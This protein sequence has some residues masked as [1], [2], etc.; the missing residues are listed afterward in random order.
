MWKFFPSL[1]FYGIKILK[2]LR[3]ALES[4]VCLTDIRFLTFILFNCKYPFK[5]CDFRIQRFSKRVNPSKSQFRKFDSETT[6][7]LPYIGK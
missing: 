2:N 3:F 4:S 5:K 6:L 1:I 7:S